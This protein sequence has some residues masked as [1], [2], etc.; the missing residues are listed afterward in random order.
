[1]VWIAADYQI[2]FL[3][4][5]VKLWGG[6]GN[7]F[8]H[9]FGFSSDDSEL[10]FLINGRKRQLKINFFSPSQFAFSVL[11]CSSLWV[12]IWGNPLWFFCE[13]G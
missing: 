8:D 9:F 5:R 2:V 1:L 13:V 7:V 6:V 12:A 10:H 4:L 11:I 3:L